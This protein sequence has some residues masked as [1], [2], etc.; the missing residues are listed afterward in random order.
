[1]ASGEILPVAAEIRA[2][3]PRFRHLSDAVVLEQSFKLSD[4]Q[5]MIA[6][7]SGF[8]NWQ[9]LKAGVKTMT[10][11]KG[12][13]ESRPVM[14]AAEP[15]LFV[16]DIKASCDFFTERLGFKV[17]FV[18][19][20]PPYYGQVVRDGARLNLRHVDVPVID[21]QAGRDRLDGFKVDRLGP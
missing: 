12:R 13:K 16:T 3:L 2:A 11:D 6:R 18:Y 8:E 5:E 15:Q 7:Q 20:E 1:M 9:A 19:G 17:A 4:A 14:T 21:R 10:E